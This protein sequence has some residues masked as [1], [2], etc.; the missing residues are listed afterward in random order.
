MV[1][2]MLRSIEINN[3]RGISRCKIRDLNRINILIGKNGSGKSTILDAIYITS[4]SVY[5]EDDI[6]LKNKL[7]Y[8]ISRHTNRGDEA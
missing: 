5:P 1:I 7:D 2:R 6:I 8:I 4:S 3:L